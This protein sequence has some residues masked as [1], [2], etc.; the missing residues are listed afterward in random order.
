M[1]RL[2]D[3]YLN[4]TCAPDGVLGEGDYVEIDP[5]NGTERFL[6]QRT[7]C[8]PIP[9]IIDSGVDIPPPRLGDVRTAIEDE[10]RRRLP[11]PTVQL[12]PD[13]EGLT[14]LETYLWYGADDLGGL[15]SIDHD[16]DPATAP[17]SGLEVTAS[18][19]P[20][21]IT[22]R[23]WIA[24]F[25]WETGDGA[26]Y[27]ST[28]PGTHTQPAAGHVYETKGNYRVVVEA[29]W[30]GSYAWSVGPVGGSGTFDEVTISGQRDYQVVEVRAVLVE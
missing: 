20:Y 16:G 27:T 25:R 12:D 2:A 10:I 29:D 18:A 4:Q 5:V 24:R 8:V 22:A 19:G 26:V 14:G 1:P 6:Y 21:T 23:A 3:F 13:H 11:T 17:I 7:E 9:D 28:S 15:Q 30:V